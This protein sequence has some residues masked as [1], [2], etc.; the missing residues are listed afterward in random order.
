MAW[1]YRIDAVP[2]DSRRARNCLDVVYRWVSAA[3]AEKEGERVEEVM[4]VLGG[5]VMSFMVRKRR[6]RSGPPSC[7]EMPRF[8]RFREMKG[9]QRCIVSKYVVV[10]SS[11]T[12]VEARIS[13]TAWEI[14]VTALKK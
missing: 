7:S 8:M 13:R 6:A 2:A 5:V 3:V 9:Y 4:S 11:I 14:S 12:L 10:V 1:R